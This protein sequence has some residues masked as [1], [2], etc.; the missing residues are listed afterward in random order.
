VARG[1]PKTEAGGGAIV[2][3]AH[4][5]IHGVFQMVPRVEL[6]HLDYATQIKGDEVVG[7]IGAIP[8]P[9]VPVSLGG[10]RAAVLHVLLDPLPPG[11]HSGEQPPATHHHDEC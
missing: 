6:D 5:N 1:I 9:D 8:Q 4:K 7:V 2:A 10:A 3:H 11:G